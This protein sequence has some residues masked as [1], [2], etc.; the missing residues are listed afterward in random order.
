MEFSKQVFP[1]N[2]S[3][4]RKKNAAL[5]QRRMICITVRMNGLVLVFPC[6]LNTLP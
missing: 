6:D 5:W 2:K 1:A 3:L 4:E